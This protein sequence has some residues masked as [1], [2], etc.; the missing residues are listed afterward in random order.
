METE[1]RMTRDDGATVEHVTECRGCEMAVARLGRAEFHHGH[2][3]QQTPPVCVA[4]SQDDLPPW[5]IYSR[6][7]KS[8]WPISEAVLEGISREG[9]KN[10]GRFSGRA[11]AP[12]LVARWRDE[13]ED[14]P[15]YQ[16]VSGQ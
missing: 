1:S 13:E 11:P 14:S 10:L 8:D 4:R 12:L 6:G 15:K 16:L 9:T 7:A 3:L 5:A 2:A